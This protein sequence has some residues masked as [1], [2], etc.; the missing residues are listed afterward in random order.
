MPIKRLLS[1]VESPRTDACVKSQRRAART[2]SRAANLLALSKPHFTL[3]ANLPRYIYILTQISPIFLPPFPFSLSIHPSINQSIYPSTSHKMP[4]PPPHLKR[5]IYTGTFISTPTPTTLEILENHAIAVDENGL[6]AHKSA[7]Q[8]KSGL[9]G[10]DHEDVVGWAER[11]WGLERGWEWVSVGD[12]VGRGW[13]F[14][15]FVG[16]WA[17]CCFGLRL[18]L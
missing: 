3:P 12:G 13:W 1:F 10:Q 15:G 11:N 9:Q 5:T 18:D 8:P 17:F 14:P 6:I 7:L 16:E 2:V 4:P